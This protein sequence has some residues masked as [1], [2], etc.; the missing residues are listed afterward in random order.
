MAIRSSKASRTDTHPWLLLGKTRAGSAISSKQLCE[1]GSLT[2]LSPLR[3]KRRRQ[4]R[5]HGMSVCGA[6]LTT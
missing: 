4:R 5:N 6:F 1:S 2:S 3:K